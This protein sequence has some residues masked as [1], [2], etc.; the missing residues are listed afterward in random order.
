MQSIWHMCKQSE[1]PTKFWSE[2]LDGRDLLKGISIAGRIIPN[3]MGWECVGWIHMVH[4]KIQ[5]WVP[6]N[7]V[8]KPQ[9]L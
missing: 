9:F 8:M 5:V 1:M 6:V 3:R 4:Y 2:Y 7:A